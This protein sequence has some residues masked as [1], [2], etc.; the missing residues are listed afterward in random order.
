MFMLKSLL[1]LFFFSSTS[2]ASPLDMSCETNY[3]DQSFEEFSQKYLNAEFSKAPLYLKD[4]II[5]N[6]DSNKDNVINAKELSTFS[7]QMSLLLPSIVSEKSSSY[8]SDNGTLKSLEFWASDKKMSSYHEF[9]ISLGD[10]ALQWLTEFTEKLPLGDSKEKILEM[11]KSGSYVVSEES[12]D[13]QWDLSGSDHSPTSLRLKALDLAYAISRIQSMV[14]TENFHLATKTLL[15][16]MLLLKNFPYVISA[17][18]APD[19][20]LSL[21]T[22]INKFDIGGIGVAGVNRYYALS[23]LGIKFKITPQGEVQRNWGQPKDQFWFLLQDPK[24]INVDSKTFMEKVSRSL[25]LL[26]KGDIE[27]FQKLSPSELSK[28]ETLTLWLQKN[29]DILANLF[30]QNPVEIIVSSTPL[31]GGSNAYTD[32]D[33]QQISF[34]FPYVE[35]VLQTLK[36]SFD[37]KNSLSQIHKNLVFILIQEWVH[38][39]QGQEKAYDNNSFYNDPADAFL[40]YGQVGVSWYE[41]QPIEKDAK[42]LARAFVKNLNNCKP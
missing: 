17:T 7:C 39:L 24:T 3:S 8:I 2:F 32:K 30:W 4:W 34:S 9:R 16:Q 13:Q 18:E 11:I 36:N 23:G 14:S 10:I 5:N 12:I 40:I 15:E 25:S 37:D 26:C 42:Q 35:S 19:T 33:A 21:S 29:S 6:V 22:H 20:S 31:K 28:P 41:D 38:I 27:S 1:L